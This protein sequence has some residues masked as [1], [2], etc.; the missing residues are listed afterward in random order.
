MDFSGKLLCRVH[1][2]S[3]KLPVHIAAAIA[4]CGYS[5]KAP[6]KKLACDNTTAEHHYAMAS[7]ILNP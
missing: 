4:A 5:R 1:P 2:T 3:R 7:K 6:E